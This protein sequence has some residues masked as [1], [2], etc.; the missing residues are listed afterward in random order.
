MENK[1]GEQLQMGDNETHPALQFLIFCAVFAG[2]W[3]L[4]NIVGAL[5][6]WAIYGLKTLMAFT[7]MDTTVPH[8]ITSL[9]ILQITS[10]TLPLFIAPFFF[11]KV[12]SRDVKEYIKPSIQINWVLMLLVLAIMLSSAPLIE[13]L[14]NINAKFDLPKWM[15]DDEDAAEKLTNVMLQMNSIWILIMDVL[16]IALLTAIAEEFVFRG[17][18]QTIFSKWTNNVHAAVW[19]T[20]ILFSAFHMEFFGF[21]PRLLLGAMFGY[22]VAW[23]G[24]I[25]T[26]V[27]AHFI[28]N[29]IDIIVTYLSQH[30]IINIDLDKQQLFN[31]TAYVFSFIIVLFLF[32]IYRD[33]ALKKLRVYQ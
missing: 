15:R 21:L 30:K 27:W 19:I 9:W 8:F 6:V 2:I 31:N 25:W 16:L 17:V 23:S 7:T 12:I 14:S 22:L 26:S 18:V 11:A 3:V 24:S 10:T 33:T 1:P 20:A 13:F 32:W 5:M 29:A 4:G 28:N